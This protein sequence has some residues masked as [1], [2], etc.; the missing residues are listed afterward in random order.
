MDSI[1]L[2]TLL[3]SSRLTVGVTIRRMI[4]ATNRRTAAMPEET[5]GPISIV[6][7]P[8]CGNCCFAGDVPFRSLGPGEWKPQRI[9]IERVDV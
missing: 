8:G 2:A 9:P 6:C 4:A 1:L 3:C 7:F 5:A